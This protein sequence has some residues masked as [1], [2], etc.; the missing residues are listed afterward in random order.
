[1]AIINKPDLQAA[2][3]N[4]MNNVT[5]ELVMRLLKLRKFNKLYDKLTAEQGVELIESIL[6]EMNV[7]CDFRDEDLKHIPKSGPF[8]VVANHPFGL[9]DGIILLH[10]IRKVRPDFKVMA[11]FLL[12]RV[13]PLKEFFIPVNPFAQKGSVVSKKGIRDALQHLKDGYPLGIFPAGEVS[14]YQ[15]MKGGVQDK[16]WEIPAIKLIK[17]AEVPVVPVYF[18]GKNSLLFHLLGKLHPSLRTA[19]LPA[20]FLGKKNKKIKVRIG[21]PISVKEQLELG[22][23]YKFGRYLRARVYVQGSALRKKQQHI[24]PN[25]AVLKRAKTI[26][27]PIPKAILKQ[28]VDKLRELGMCYHK[29]QD[30]EIYVAPYANIPNLITEIGRLREITFREVGEGTNLA[31][32]LDRYDTKYEHLF[33]WHNKEQKVIGA[34]R[35]GRGKVLSE[36]KGVKGFYTN[37]LFE[38]NKKLLPILEQSVELGRSFVIKEYQQHPMPLFLLWRGIL[39]FLLKN[40][41]YKYLVGPVS[42]SNDYST[43][44]KSYI[45]AFIMK[46]FY[47]NELAKLVKPRTGYK[48]DFRHSDYEILLEKAKDILSFDKLITEIEPN[49]FHIPPLLKQYIKLNAKIISFNMDPKFNNSLDGLILLDLKEVPEQT[50]EKLKSEIA[51]N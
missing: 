8:I 36:K 23:V 27:A 30:I 16:A 17:H 38:M 35:L 43:V 45:I 39:I 25:L 22:D 26:I 34:Y 11:N 40:P 28:E 7:K 24:R 44:S 21:S 48:V 14:T 20:E 29:H 50:M 13:E 51:K 4:R 37:T 42:I 46:Y 31:V 32:D 19:R 1:M 3:G 47:N 41:E 5:A 6:K 15:S 2:T 33:L 18:D 10:L 9:L 49:R 12:H